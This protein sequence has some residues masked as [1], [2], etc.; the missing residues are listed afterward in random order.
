MHTGTVFAILVWILAHLSLSQIAR[1][2]FY[3]VAVYPTANIT[4]VKVISLL[5]VA[6][7]NVTSAV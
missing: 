2:G 4:R 3:G 7:T 1:L 5:T 6:S